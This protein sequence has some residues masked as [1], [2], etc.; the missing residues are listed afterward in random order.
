[1]RQSNGGFQNWTDGLKQNIIF[2]DFDGVLVVASTNFRAADPSCVAVLN[3]I[4][5][6]GE[7]ALVI[8]STWRL[9]S[10]YANDAT[11]KTIEYLQELLSGWGVD[12]KVVGLTPHLTRFHPNSWRGSEINA[13]LEANPD[14]YKNFVILDDDGDMNP[15][16]SKLVKTEFKVGL[17]SHHIE[18]ALAL[19]CS[20]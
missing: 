12:G 16:M 10:P 20:E 9:L 14:A 8:S 5:K 19:L 4:I 1:M 17:Q 11:L 18:K 13:W 7:A 3:Q 6:Q 2:L 15:W